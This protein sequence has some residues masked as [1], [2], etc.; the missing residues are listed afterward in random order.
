[1]AAVSIWKVLHVTVDGPVTMPPVDN[2]PSL[3]GQGD[4][5]LSDWFS[6]HGNYPGVWISMLVWACCTLPFDDVIQ[7]PTCLFGQERRRQVSRSVAVFRVW[8]R[9]LQLSAT[10]SA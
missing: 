7:R 5:P 9:P 8:Q 3:L 10:N 2:A 6:V 4:I 1:M